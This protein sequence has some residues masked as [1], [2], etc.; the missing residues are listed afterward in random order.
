M[1]QHLI[2]ALAALALIPITDQNSARDQQGNISIQF[3]Q[4]GVGLSFT[5]V[6][7]SPGRISLQLSS[8]VSELTNTGSFVLPG[9]QGTGLTIPA[10]SVRRTETT[11]ELPSGG[12]FELL[13][14]LVISY[15]LAPSEHVDL[16]ESESA[17]TFI[18]TFI[19][20]AFEAAL[21]RS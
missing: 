16:G 12:S 6:V 14:R 21:I 11:V 13:S 19:L 17:R 1:T 2:A 7:I 9:S 5:P 4:F 18:N 20:P 8:E 3:K 15:F 10:L